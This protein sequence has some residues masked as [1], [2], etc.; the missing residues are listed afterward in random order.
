MLHELSSSQL[1]ELEAYWVINGGFGDYKQEYRF[2][3]LCSLLANINRDSKRKP[4]PFSIN[5]FLLIPQQEE[6]EQKENSIRA[7]FE[8]LSKVKRKKR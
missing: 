8:F 5:D 7:F 2:A 3:Q 4:Q 6:P 1:T